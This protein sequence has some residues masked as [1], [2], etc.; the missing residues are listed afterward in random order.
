MPQLSI[1]IPLFNSCDFISRALQSCINQTLKDVEI[2]IIDDKSKDNSLNIVLEFAKK[3]FKEFVQDNK[4][5]LKALVKFQAQNLGIENIKDCGICSFDD[6]SFF[7]YRRDKT[8]KRFVSVVY[9]KD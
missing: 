4:L 5:D 3:E 1:I 9:L 8:P 2:L 6:E 7:S